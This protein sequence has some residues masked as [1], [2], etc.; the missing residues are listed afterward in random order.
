MTT[1]KI[2]EYKIE[3]KNGYEGKELDIGIEIESA[4]STSF[5]RVLTF[6]PGQ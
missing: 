2:S 3:K 6:R 5:L 1:E 4:S